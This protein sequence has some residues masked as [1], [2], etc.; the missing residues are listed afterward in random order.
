[1]G[2]PYQR[3]G[4]T[5]VHYLSVEGERRNT[6]SVRLC[7]QIPRGSTSAL[8]ECIQVHG[9]LKGL[10]LEDPVD[11]AVLPKPMTWVLERTT[12]ATRITLYCNT[13]CNPYWPVDAFWYC[14]WRG[15]NMILVIRPTFLLAG[16]RR[17][18]GALSSLW[19]QA[20]RPKDLQP[21]WEKDQSAIT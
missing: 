4:N 20:F 19:P 15:C 11:V 5:T 17:A 3:E 16:Q 21:M 8:N 2:S 7:R 6:Y 12:S 1:M 14:L 18:Q 9:R 10:Y 13:T